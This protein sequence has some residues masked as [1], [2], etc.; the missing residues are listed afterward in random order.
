M[1]DGPETTKP[2]LACVAFCAPPF[3]ETDPDLWFLQL[4]FQF[5][6][7]GISIDKTKFLTVLAKILSYVSDIVRNPPADNNGYTG[8]LH[9]L[10]E[11]RIKRDKTPIIW[12]D[13]TKEAFQACKELLKNAAMLTYP[14]HNTPLSLVTDASETAIGAVLQQHVEGGTEPL[15]FFS[16]KLNAAER[17]Y[18]TYDRE[19]LVIYSAIRFF[20]FVEG[21]DLL[22]FTDH[23]PLTYAFK[24]NHEKNSPTQIRH[25]GSIGQFTTDLRYIS[26]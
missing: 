15:S 8:C 16:R 6:L 13:E 2:E 14:K 22:V 3:W 18:S 20:R 1:P 5:K 24:Q 21:R 11:G 17:K 10:V 25:L 4:E 7:S 23:K 19:R 9:D 26:G 12:T